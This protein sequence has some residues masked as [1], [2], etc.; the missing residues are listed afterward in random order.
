MIVSGWKCLKYA[1]VTTNYLACCSKY[2]PC[3]KLMLLLKEN[4]SVN[5]LTV[6]TAGLFKFREKNYVVQK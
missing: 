4:P 2:S 1:S 3:V 6:K 5:A